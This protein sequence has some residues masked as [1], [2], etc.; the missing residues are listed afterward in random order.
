MDNVTGNSLGGALANA[1]AVENPQ[2]RSVT[3]NPALLP[4]TAAYDPTTII[5]IAPYYHSSP[6]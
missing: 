3:Y 5:L 2:V 4:A 6:T 1:V